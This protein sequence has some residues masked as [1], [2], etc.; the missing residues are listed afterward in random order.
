MNHR[1]G[2]FFVAAWGLVLLPA[3]CTAGILTHPCAPKESNQP[4]HHSH[5]EDDDGQCRHESDCAQDPCNEIAV[6]DHREDLFTAVFSVDL[7]T[8]ERFL[9]DEVIGQ[10]DFSHPFHFEILDFSNL[11]CLDSVLPLLI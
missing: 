10:C 3:L 9:L 5:G 7:L 4:I 2:T 8:T 1:L 6:R 11:P